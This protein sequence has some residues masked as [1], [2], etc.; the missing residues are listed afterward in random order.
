MQLQVAVP[1]YSKALSL[2]SKR[3]ASFLGEVLWDFLFVFND[4][5]AERAQSS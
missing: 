2:S 4:T 3:N 5:K 1:F